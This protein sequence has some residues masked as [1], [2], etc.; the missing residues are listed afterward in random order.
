[1]GEL[2]GLFYAKWR[3]VYATYHIPFPAKLT[4]DMIYNFLILS[5]MEIALWENDYYSLLVE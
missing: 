2:R 4:F 1:M 5:L 3:D